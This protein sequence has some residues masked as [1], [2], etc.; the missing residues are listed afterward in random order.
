M[1]LMQ[2]QIHSQVLQ[3][4][5]DV[6]ALVPG[7]EPG[8]HTGDSRTPW[9]VLWLLH[10]GV[11][12]HTFWLRHTQIEE[13]AA[14][15]E[16]VAVIMPDAYGSSCVDTAYGARFGTYLG[17]ELPQIMRSVLPGLSSRREDNWIAGFSNGGY[18]SLY[19][20]L[21]FSQTYGSI[22][23]YGAGDKADADFSQ[24]GV[25]KERLF[26]KGDLHG[27]RYSVVHLAERLAC[28][29]QV[30]PRIFHGCGELD[31]WRDMNETV[32][33]AILQLPGDPYQYEFKLWEG[34][35][36]TGECC[37]AVM[38]HFLKNVTAEQ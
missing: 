19:L 20:G 4:Q 25:E 21:A 10:G 8:W 3:M 1:V 27:G 15:C 12:D 35:G 16:N 37:S 11:G 36:H 33:D 38:R 34:L 2:C 31:P 17:Q 30:K 18:G 14:S 28:S 22:G 26:G 5:T 7:E 13:I 29:D 6:W 24:N 9:K 32:R 23:A